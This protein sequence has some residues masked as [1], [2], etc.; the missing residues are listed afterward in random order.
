MPDVEDVIAFLELE[1][2]KDVTLIDLHELGRKDLS[3]YA[4]IVSTFSCRHNHSI[5]SSLLK[6][7]K[8]INI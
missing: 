4:I 5:A 7:V 1:Q 8:E 2:G 6:A 3:Q